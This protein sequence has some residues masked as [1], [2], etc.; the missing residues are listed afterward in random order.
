[1]DKADHHTNTLKSD[2]GSNE[3]GTGIAAGIAIGIAIGVA[4]DNIGLWLPLGIAIGVG[5]SPVFNSKSSKEK[6]K[7]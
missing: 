3:M 4:T 1:M 5:L 6:N 7:V 2:Q